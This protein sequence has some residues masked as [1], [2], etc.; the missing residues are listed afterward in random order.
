MKTRYKGREVVVKLQKY[1]L[2]KVVANT[3]NI[4]ADTI[5][6][7]LVMYD[8]C[9]NTVTVDEMANDSYAKYAALHECICCGP[10]KELAPSTKDDS[11]RCGLIDAML[12]ESMTQ[13]EKT[14]YIKKRIE[15]FETLIELHL[16]P[17][18]EAQFRESLKILKNL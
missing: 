10:Y 11:K 15:M 17:P 8:E 7:S 13:E 5:T 14:E 18:L 6:D 4:A 9:T 2:K 12:I 3:L 16:S 1:D